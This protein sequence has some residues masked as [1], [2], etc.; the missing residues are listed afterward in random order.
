[1]IL[2]LFDVSQ[3][4]YAGMNKDNKVVQGVEDRGGLIVPREMPAGGLAFLLEELEHY[5][6][7][8]T[9]LVCCIDSPPTFKRELYDKEIPFGG[10]YKGNRPAKVPAISI[11]RKAVYEILKHIGYNTIKVDGYEADDI[12][13]SL[14]K[15]YKDSYE[16]IYIHSKDSDLYYLVDTNVECMPIGYKNLYV[17]RGDNRSYV[18][19]TGGKHITRSN[20]SEQ[21]MTGYVVPWNTL[22]LNKMAKGES[23]DNIPP[24]PKE[25]MNKIFKAIP[26]SLAP[27]CGDN[28][29]L[30]KLIHE[31][32]N[33]DPTT[34]TIM[35]LIMPLIIRYDSVMLYDE[36]INTDV[37]DFYMREF[38]MRNPI[39]TAPTRN[40]LG[41]DILNKY[42]NMY[43]DN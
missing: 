20:W 16:K 4:I 21:V 28:D 29:F 39:S 41:E 32:T 11:Q 17:G 1:M 13:A 36:D 15:Y 14:V 8:N 26:A 6:N 9:T 18:R 7:E 22:T 10:G 40:S 27:S 2:R 33:S 5:K 43:M 24:V 23:G 3:Y 31:I 19:S 38:G 30:R 12:I 35:E 34:I 37:L 42:I 25:T